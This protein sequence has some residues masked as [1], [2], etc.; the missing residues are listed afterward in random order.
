VEQKEMGAWLRNF[1]YFIEYFS[2][3]DCVKQKKMALERL[4][5]I[6]QQIEGVLDSIDSISKPLWIEDIKNVIFF[7]F[8]ILINI[9]VSNSNNNNKLLISKVVTS[10][11]ELILKDYFKNKD[12]VKALQFHNSVVDRFSTVVN[13]DS[14]NNPY[15]CY[16]PL[17]MD[18]IDHIDTVIY[19]FFK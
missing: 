8:S 19:Q 12:Y 7:P 9:Q 14:N 17:N 2:L 6:F 3:H 13:D 11:Y 1:I 15:D 5:K 10:L 4:D 18:E 16:Y